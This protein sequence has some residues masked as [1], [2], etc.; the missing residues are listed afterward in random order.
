MRVQVVNTVTSS[1]MPPKNGPWRDGSQRAHQH[2]EG[3]VTQFARAWHAGQIPWWKAA[4]A[5]AVPYGVAGA[6]AYLANKYNAGGSG[7]ARTKVG[8]GMH[9]YK[10]GKG[11]GRRRKR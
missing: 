7:K 1:N 11:K 9:R 8:R 5:I 4:A 2:V 10:A 6:S 3:G